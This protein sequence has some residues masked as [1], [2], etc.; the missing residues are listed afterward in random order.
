VVSVCV[1]WETVDGFAV[2]GKGE[3]APAKG[4]EDV[5]DEDQLSSDI[6]SISFSHTDML[7]KR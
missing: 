1:A 7:S 4:V 2:S 3:G 6:V 5:H